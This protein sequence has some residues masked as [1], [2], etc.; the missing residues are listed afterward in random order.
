[1]P[2]TK[3]TRVWAP[4]TEVQVQGVHG[5]IVKS[6][7]WTEKVE[8]V[9]DWMVVTF[10]QEA[11]WELDFEA[12]SRW[13]MINY[14]LSPA[15]K[16][17]QLLYAS[18]EKANNGRIWARALFKMV[19]DNFQRPVTDLVMHIGL[20]P[21]EAAIQIDAPPPNLPRGNRWH[22]ARLACAQYLVAN[23]LVPNGAEARDKLYRVAGYPW[24]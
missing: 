9:P 17:N 12:K 8:S 18:L 19:A 13:T 21:R 22:L 1:M 10:P 4:A 6:G 23:G 24:E 15:L 20:D 2:Y 7:T 3:T 11:V 5:P 14:S 16:K